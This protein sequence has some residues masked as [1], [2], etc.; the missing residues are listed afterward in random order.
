MLEP[1]KA[2]STSATAM[3]KMYKVAKASSRLPLLY[4]FR[5]RMPDRYASPLN[6]LLRQADRDTNFERRLHLLSDLLVVGRRHAFPPGDQ[7]A[8][9]KSLELYQQSQ[10]MY[11]EIG[12]HL[13][14]HVL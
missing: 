4:H 9:R 2:E 6:L 11:R 5:N 8:I 3:K 12:A 14:H 1:A 13:I 10:S 7:D